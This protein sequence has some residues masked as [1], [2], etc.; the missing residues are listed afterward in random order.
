MRLPRR[1]AH[2]EGAE[3]VE[4]LGELRT[5]LF[6]CVVAVGSCFV[7]GYIVHAQLIQLLEAPLPH[8]RKL[9]TY[10]V[11]EPFMTSIQVSLA[12][13]FALALP[14]VLW[15][16]WS[17]LAP[18]FQPHVQ[19]VVA[20]CVGAGCVLFAGGLAF[21]Y[22]VALPAALKFL[23]TY[24]EAIY[25]IQI[26]AKDYVSFS[27]MVLVAVGV[28]FELPAV[29]VTV[30]RLGIISSDALRQ[31]RRIGYVAVAALAV[32]LPGVDPVTTVFEMVPLLVLFEASIWFSVLVERRARLRLAESSV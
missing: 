30:V 6:I 28:V 1:L 29:V 10:G 19:R 18:A 15:Q 21:G 11:A 8:D 16:L 25:N 12:A 23:T 31:H 9:V 32:A 4:H 26:R 13:G 5:R 20:G 17:Y 24:D 27:V 3:L 7:A 2:G 22:T 14:I